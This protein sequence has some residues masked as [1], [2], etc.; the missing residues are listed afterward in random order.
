[1]NTEKNISEKLIRNSTFNLIGFVLTTPIQFIIIP[2]II[3]HIGV[4]GYGI[5]ALVISFMGY[6]GLS[7][8][9]ISP[10]LTKFIAEYNA[11]NDQTIINKLVNTAFVI[12]VFV[13]IIISIIFM[14]LA[15]WLIIVFFKPSPD[16]IPV[17]RFIFI[18]YFLLFIINMVFT[19]YT[20]IITGLQRY[21][22]SNI[23]N[24]V[25][26]LI[27]MAGIFFFFF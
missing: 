7:D 25:V 14:L 27:S 17:I 6:V 4:N 22:I 11:H 15:E 19:A 18:G 21:D 26:A 12:Y 2:Y 16:M 24:I 13:G 9:G 1:M 10:A 5:W 23:I 3:S 20:S 8:L